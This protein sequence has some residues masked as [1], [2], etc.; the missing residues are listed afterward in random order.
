MPAIDIIQGANWGSEAKGSVAGFLALQRKYAYAVRT[1]AINAG[2]TVYYKNKPYINQQLPVAWVCPT[3]QLVIGP[4]AYVHMPTL[5][6]EI[7]MI[8]GAT[9]ESAMGFKLRLL[10]DSRVAVHKGTYAQESADVNRHHKIGATGKGCAEAII[11]KI[12][13]RGDE[14]L[15]LRDVVG[16]D[17]PWTWVEAD[18]LLTGAYDDGYSIMLEGTQG[19]LLDF[20]LGPWP[21]VTSR[22][23]TAAAWVAEAGLSPALK[24]NVILVARTYPIRVAGNSGPMPRE[25]TWPILLDKWNHQLDSRGVFL[26]HPLRVDDA[27]LVQYMRVVRQIG[28]GY[29]VDLTTHHVWSDETRVKYKSIL[30]EFPT[31]AMEMVTPEAREELMRVMEFTTVT[32]KLRRVAEPNFPALGRTIRRLKPSMVVLTFLNYEFP[33]LH[34]LMDIHDEARQWVAAMC[35]QASLVNIGPKPHSFVWM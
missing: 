35:P 18:T 5:E 13:D 17:V 23:T 2:H 19:E 6:R 27:H 21:Y 7:N 28:D 4:G 11:H 24:Y 26:T 29:G 10:I 16:E 14:P 20:H 12:K 15:L 22:Q 3:T 8:R 33:E 32:K 9:G 1:G 25:I 34:G 30:S 31:R